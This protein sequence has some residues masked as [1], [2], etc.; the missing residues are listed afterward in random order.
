MVCCLTFLSFIDR[1]DCLCVCWGGGRRAGGL[2]LEPVDEKHT[3]VTK[4]WDLYTARELH[5]TYAPVI[6]TTA[7]MGSGNSGDIDFS[8]RKARIYAQHCGDIFYGKSPVQIP[9]GNCEI[10]PAGLGMETK[11]LW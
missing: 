1:L 7:P 2:S 6:V 9:V 5:L 8:L 3:F 11:A 4:P 10:I